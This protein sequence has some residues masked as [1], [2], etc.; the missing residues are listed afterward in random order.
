MYIV[1]L[2]TLIIGYIFTLSVSIYTLIF[3]FKHHNKFGIKFNAILAFSAIFNAVF[4]YSI[5]FL[6]SII[7]FFSESINI[8]I[9]KLSLI[10]GFIGLLITSLIYTFLKEFK[11]V[12]YFP[13]LIFIILFGLLIGSFFSPGSV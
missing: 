13:F 11:M 3:I 2:I 9:W 7:I 1:I 6:F 10:F 4:V 12:P 5:L 8:F